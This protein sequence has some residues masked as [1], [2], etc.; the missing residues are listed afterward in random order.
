MV[1]GEI[2][3]SILP[4]SLLGCVLVHGHPLSGL[5]PFLSSYLHF[6]NA[7]VRTRVFFAFDFFIVRVI[8][9]ACV[10][11][12]VVVF[13]VVVDVV[14]ASLGHCNWARSQFVLCGSRDT[15]CFMRGWLTGSSGP[16]S[17]QPGVDQAFDG[18]RQRGRGQL[19]T[20]CVL[21]T[22]C[23]IACLVAPWR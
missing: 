11:F 15:C 3:P 16:K 1:N 7:C 21:G 5:F 14:I 18:R 4:T 13:S 17:A 22:R 12:G 20:R 19:P 2:P 23:S 6:L 8:V 9:F 10:L